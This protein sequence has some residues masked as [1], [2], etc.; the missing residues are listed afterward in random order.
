MHD[1][2]RSGNPYQAQGIAQLGSLG[3]RWCGCGRGWNRPRGGTEQ[4]TRLL[5]VAFATMIICQRLIERTEHD[6]RSV[7]PL[8][9]RPEERG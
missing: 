1:M 6:G 4:G 5:I 7:E 9:E 2:V 3:K 8:W